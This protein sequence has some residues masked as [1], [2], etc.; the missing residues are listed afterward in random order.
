MTSANNCSYSGEKQT[1]L[2]GW[3]L[4]RACNLKMWRKGVT[5]APHKPV[6]LIYALSKCAPGQPTTMSYCSVVAALTPVLKV[7]QGNRPVVEPRYPFWRLQRDG[8]WQ[9]TADSPMKKRRGNTDPLHSELVEKNAYGGL[10]HHIYEMLATDRMFR[11]RVIRL[12]L[13]RYFS[14]DEQKALASVLPLKNI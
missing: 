13:E 12:V 8:L 7:L 2:Q 5:T 9:V 3:L 4:S 14:D 6:L 11:D 10:P 1:D